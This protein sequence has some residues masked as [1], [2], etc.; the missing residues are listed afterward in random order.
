MKPSTKC[1]NGA[2]TISDC[3]PS[4]KT[5]NTKQIDGAVEIKGNDELKKD[6]KTTFYT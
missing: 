1:I 5:T 3:T 2:E 6:N 4:Q